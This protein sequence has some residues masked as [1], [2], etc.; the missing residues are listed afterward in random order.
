[1]A[2]HVGLVCPPWLIQQWERPGLPGRKPWP[3]TV[4]VALLVMRF[5]GEGIRRRAAVREAKNNAQW[6]AALREKW[7]DETP[8]KRVVARFERFLL[9]RDPR[10]G[11]PRYLQLFEHIGRVCMDAGVLGKRPVWAMDSTPMWCFGAVL[12]TTRQLGDGVRSLAS[13]WARASGSTVEQLSTDWG[14]PLRRAKSTKGWL[15]IDWSDPVARAEALDKLAQV[16]LDIASRV[17]S[18]VETVRANK[19]KGL[20]RR[21]R[22]LA[23]VVSQDLEVDEEGRLVVAKRVAAQRLVSVTDPE[24]RHGRKSRSVTF[25][26]FKLHVLGDVVSGF[27]VAACVTP[28]NVHDS[29]PACRLIERAKGLVESIE[30]VLGDTA[31]GAARL[32]HVVDGIA[33]VQ[34]LAP[35]PMG[36]TLAGRLGKQDFEVELETNT[37]TC[38]GGVTVAQRS[39]SFSKEHGVKVPVFKWTAQTCAGCPLRDA[40]MGDAKG[41][42][43]VLLHP[44]ESE[45]RA[46]REAWEAPEVRADYRTRSQ[47]ER[48]VHQLTRHGGRRARTWGLGPAQLQAHTIA[49]GCNLDLLARRLAAGEGGGLTRSVCG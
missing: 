15:S 39:W 27:M 18:R 23:R 5:R 12:D 49:I 8:G 1:L 14:C 38:P 7:T 30:R 40:C 42:K 20:L 2:R 29:A 47:C 37:S 16:A 31:Y 24:A 48:R 22:N 13:E 11:V 9:R 35:S 4:L 34:L 44:Y 41:G 33:D 28:G 19:R 17:R 36:R 45:L 10:T 6:R 26:G 3:T 32:R 43:R 21:C 46:A 25:N